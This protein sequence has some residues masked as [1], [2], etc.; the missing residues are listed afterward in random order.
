MVITKQ[1]VATSGSGIMCIPPTQGAG[2]LTPCDHQ[3]AYTRM[4]VHVADAVNEG[5]KKILIRLVDTDVVVLAV[6]AA[7]KLDLEEL[8]IAFGTGKNFCHIP[9][10]EIAR[11]SKSTAL[12]MLT[13]GATL[14]HLMTT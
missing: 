11:S 14:Y 12:F 10:H 13:L 6:A 7:A 4:F 5:Y 9:A 3:E 8:W 1:I 2:N